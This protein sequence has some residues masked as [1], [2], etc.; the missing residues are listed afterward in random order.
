[1]VPSRTL[2]LDIARRGPPTQG[3]RWFFFFVLGVAVGCGGT[4]AIPEESADPTLAGVTYEVRPDDRLERLAVRACFDG[5]PPARLVAPEPAAELLAEVRGPRGEALPHAET[6]TLPGVGPGECVRWKVDLRRAAFTREVTLRGGE[7]LLAPGLLLWRPPQRGLPLRVRFELPAGV[8]AS[9]PWVQAGV[10]RELSTDDLRV[11][12]NLA[13]TRSPPLRIRE[14][15]TE[16]EA[17]VFAGQLA[18]NRAGLERWLRAAVRAVDTFG[19]GFPVEYLHVAVLPSGPGWRPVAFGLVRRGGGPSVM[20]L[21]HD[22]IP[23]AALVRDW[24]AVHELSHLAMPRMYEEDRWISE[25]LA[26]YFQEVLRARGG[27]ISEEDAWA[28]IASGFERGRAVGTGRTLWREARDVMRTGAFRRI[29]WAGAAWA[30]EADLLLRERGRTLDGLL[31]ESRPRWSRRDVWHGREL[32]A[33]CDAVLG[34]PLLLPLAERYGAQ[35]AFEGFDELLRSIGV[36]FDH[37]LVLAE[38]APRAALRRTIT[39]PR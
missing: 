5:V 26:T 13:F 32:L 14:A 3:V 38:D 4:R 39:A 30:L 15:E 33:E 11:P 24:T 22:E 2:A 8:Y 20:L 21:V 36:G 37:D 9:G 10:T 25:G 7:A 35:T 31:A 18:V 6:I 28:A 1:M 19:D 34:E 12:G 29:Y 23:E 27:L 16:L 17:A